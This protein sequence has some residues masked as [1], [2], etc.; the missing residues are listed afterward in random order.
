MWEGWAQSRRR[1]GRGG[2]S[3]GADVGGVGPVPA[4]MWASQPQRPTENWCIVSIGSSPVADT[5][6]SAS[7]NRTTC[8]DIRTFRKPS[9]RVRVRVRACACV[10]VRACACA[11]VCVRVRACAF[12]RV[13]LCACVCARAPAGRCRRATRGARPPR[14]A[15]S[16]ARPAGSGCRL[17]ANKQKHRIRRGSPAAGARYSQVLACAE[18][19][20]AKPADGPARN[21]PPRQDPEGRD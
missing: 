15:G 7:R 5:A 19:P 12:V 8:P 13:C 21:P 3:P 1:C 16:D 9:P 20:R 17:R 14:A 18:P 6:T 11:C 4:P 10:R 2:P